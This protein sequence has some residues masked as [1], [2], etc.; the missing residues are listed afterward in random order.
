MKQSKL[1]GKTTKEIPKDEVSK[2]AELL[3][4]S[5][6]VDK[7]MA[8]VYTYLPLGLR[9][10]KKIQA[11]VREEMETLG[12]Q[13]IYMP[14]LTPK[15]NW[16]KTS[17]WDEIDVLFKLQGTGDKEYALGSTHEEIVT[18]LV[19]KFVNSY[20]DLPVAVYQIQ[21][22][23]RDEA[24]AKSGLLRGREFSMKDLYSFHRNEEDLADFYEKSKQA[25]L[26]VFKRCGLDA[27]IVEASGGV[28]SK[29][30]H[31]FQVFT[32]S[33]EDKIYV[34]NSCGRHQNEE[35]VENQTLKCPYCG[36][37]RIIEKSIEV[38]NIF[39][40]KTKFTTAFD[41]TYTDEAGKEQPVQMGC[42]GI[43]PSRV[44]GSVV[45]VHH[46]DKGMIWPESMAPYQVHLVALG[47][48]EK[49]LAQAESLYQEL[50]KSGVETLFD[51]REVQAGQKL[52]DADLIGLPIRL[53]I[54]SKTLDK[55]FVEMKKRNSSE[56]ELIKI[57]KVSKLFTK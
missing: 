1:F 7:L 36:N 44:M 41:F 11:I 2:N 57:A 3:I 31:E 4:R 45:E 16:V 33:G 53:I 55:N 29:F 15:D 14:A 37:D 21:D 42:Y 48:D 54:S 39:E 18:P 50:I 19:K 25:Y 34:C 38:G 23:F 13:E 28:F 47:D 51:D 30:S 9:V 46:D 5:G 26:N 20:K 40:L 22:K 24:R 17:R 52:N 35:I 8:G 43:G 6:F 10:L 49:V 32:E 56:V 27:H 12:G